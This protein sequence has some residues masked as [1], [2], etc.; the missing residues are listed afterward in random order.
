VPYIDRRV[1]DMIITGGNGGNASALFG[2]SLVTEVAHGMHMCGV[3]AQVRPSRL[4]H[5]IAI[6]EQELR[7]MS[8]HTPI[9]HCYAPLCSD[10]HLMFHMVII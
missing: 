7:R 6:V 2:A 9:V 5:A 4:L 10:L 1:S 8:T 3:A